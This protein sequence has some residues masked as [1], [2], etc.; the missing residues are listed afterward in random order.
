MW[1]RIGFC[2]IIQG[3]SCFTPHH[4]ERNKIMENENKNKNNA[5]A[6]QEAKKAS[7]ILKE[8]AAKQAA[9]E[10]PEIDWD[11]LPRT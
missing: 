2:V 3:E 9:D 5:P 11:E 6:K 4:K 8:K 1:K 10:L 7:D